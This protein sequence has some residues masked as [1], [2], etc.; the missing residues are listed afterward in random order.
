[1]RTRA[2]QSMHFGK[3]FTA[4]LPKKFARLFN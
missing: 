3:N 2:L 4:L 1:L